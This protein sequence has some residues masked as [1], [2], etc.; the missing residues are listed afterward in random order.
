[1]LRALAEARA[2]PFYS[3]WIHLGYAVHRQSPKIEF[4]I[5]QVF[6]S[7]GAYLVLY[8]SAIRQDQMDVHWSLTLAV[9]GESIKIS[10]HVEVETDS[11]HDE[12][13]ERCAVV[14]SATDAVQ[15]I[16]RFAAAVCAERHWFDPSA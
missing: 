8:V 15:A 5:H 3:L 6:P 12:V 7:D 2:G 13:F 1:M 10:A 16:E 14:H 4:R 9:S 11:G